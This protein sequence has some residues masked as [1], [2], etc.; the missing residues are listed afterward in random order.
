MVCARHQV[1]WLRDEARMGSVLQPGYG[2]VTA[3]TQHQAGRAITPR[4]QA[5]QVP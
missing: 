5:V 3:D 2:S 4:S 1:S